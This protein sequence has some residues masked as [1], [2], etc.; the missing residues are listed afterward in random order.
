MS[1]QIDVQD[2]VNGL[3]NQ[4]GEQA[5]EIALLRIQLQIAVAKAPVEEGEANG[6]E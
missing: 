1:D 3:L 2:I 5:K 4:V 6:D